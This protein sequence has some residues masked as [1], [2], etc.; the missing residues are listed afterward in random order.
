MVIQQAPIMR[1][2]LKF[3]R[4]HG[5][6][7]FLFLK[8]MRCLRHT[9]LVFLLNCL[10]FSKLLKILHSVLCNFN[11]LLKHKQSSMKS[12]VCHK[13]YTARVGSYPSKSSSLNFGERENCKFTP[14][15]ETYLFRHTRSLFKISSV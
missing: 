7:Q 3:T 14:P 4:A 1:R 2:W 8:R 12:I 15:S 6:F 13:L 5:R 10:R 11:Y 9:M